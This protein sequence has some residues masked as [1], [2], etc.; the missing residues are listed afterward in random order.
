MIKIGDILKLKSKNSKGIIMIDVLFALMLA[1]LIT[2]MG[3]IMIKT[4]S[5]VTFD[6]TTLQNQL[7]IIQ[8]RNYL[9]F[10]DEFEVNDNELNY[11]INNEEFHLRIVNQRLIQQ[12]GTLIFLLNIDDVEFYLVEDEIHLTY[13]LNEK[14]IDQ[15]IAYE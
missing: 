9:N 15:L 1:L 8:L 7:G 14:I 10:A 13:N 6:S 4:L 2:Q 5:L 12:P 3:N 11:L